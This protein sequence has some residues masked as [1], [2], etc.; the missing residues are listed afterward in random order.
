V[1]AVSK[2]NGLVPVNMQGALLK[3]PTRYID[4]QRQY[5]HD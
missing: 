1:R 2:Q 5:Q 4:R 3:P